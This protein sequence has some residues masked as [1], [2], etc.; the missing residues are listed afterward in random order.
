MSYQVLA[1]KWRPGTFDDLVGQDHVVRALKNALDHNRVHHAFLFT[2]TRGVGKTTI[3]RIFS[4]ALNCET[5]ITSTPCGQC[6]AC[7]E[8]DEGRFVDLIEV[9]AASRTKVDDTRE[10]LDNVQYLPTRGR[11]K[12]YLIDEVHMLSTHS[13]NALLKTLEEPPEHVKFLLATTDP[14]KLPITVLSRCLQFNLKR[15]PTD[16]INEYLASMLGSESVP[17]EADAVAAIARAADGSMRDGLSLLDQAIAYGNGQLETEDVNTMLGTIRHEHIAGIISALIDSDSAA[18]WAVITELADYVPDYS[19]V[20]DALIREVHDAS[21]SVHLLKSHVSEPAQA[22]AA[23]VDPTL[24]Q[25]YYQILLHGKQDIAMAPE[26]SIGFEM[27]LLRLLTYRPLQPGEQPVDAAGNSSQRSAPRPVQSATAT[28]ERSAAP[29]PSDPSSPTSQQAMSAP[30][31]AV[32]D[33]PPAPVAHPDHQVQ[34]T[35]ASVAPEAQ[36]PVTGSPQSDDWLSLIDRLGLKGPVL[37]LAKHCILL[38]ESDRQYQLVLD[39]QYEHFY[40]PAAE[41]KI[42]ESMHSLFGPDASIRFSIGETGGNTVAEKEIQQDRQTQDQALSSMQ[43]DETVQALQSEFG[44]EL[45]SDSI[46][47]IS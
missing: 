4:K 35:R 18:L 41:Q 39:R 25:L 37:M 7:T 28:S 12:V 43:A 44:A 8:I 27:T 33:Q 26:P 23:Q 14:E 22:L 20:I 46:R 11:F 13:F 31:S 30:E 10:L 42:L 38:R 29:A 6:A 24:L 5:G 15:L 1:R 34:E 32:P 2:G 36:A 40:L 16:L 3:A 21:L 45:I 47:P 9:D 17:F 19:H